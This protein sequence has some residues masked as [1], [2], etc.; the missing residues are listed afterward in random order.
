MAISSS[1]SIRSRSRSRR[2]CAALFTLFAFFLLVLTGERTA[3]G[4]AVEEVG[5]IVSNNNNKALAAVSV[6]ARVKHH[7]SISVAEKVES[8]THSSEASVEKHR[9]DGPHH[10]AMAAGSLKVRCGQGVE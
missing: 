8:A 2:P 9:V 3:E 1:S 10:R 6:R 5:A 7:S 4:A